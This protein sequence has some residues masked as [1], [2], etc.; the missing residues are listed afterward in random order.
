MRFWLRWSWRD[1]RA[2]WVQIA[3]IAL[4]IA[5]GTG[6][7]AGMISMIEWRDQ[8]QRA[9]FESLNMYDLRVRL[10]DG[11]YVGEGSLAAALATIAHPE[12]IDAAEERL[13]STVQV[14]VDIDGETVLAVGPIV[15]VDIA[16]GGPRVNGIYTAEGRGLSDAD[17]GQDIV[18]IARAFGIAHNLPRSGEI[19]IAGGRVLRYV[20]QGLSPEYFSAFASTEFGGFLTPATYAPLFMPLATA[21]EIT[22]QPGQVNDLVVALT[23][24][25][26]R[27]A[28]AAEI[29]SALERELPDTGF[30]I[31]RTEDDPAWQAIFD[32]IEND[33]RFLTIFA[34]LIFLGAVG[35]AFSL[36]SRVIESQRREIGIAMSLGVPRHRIAIRPLLAGAEIALLGVLFGVLVGFLLGIPLQSFLLDLQPL[37]RWEFGFQYGVFAQAAIIGFVLPFLATSIPVVRAVRVSPLQAMQ[38]GYR[39]ARGGGL[40]RFVTWLRIPGSIFAQIPVRNLLRAPRRSILT[41]LGIAAA[42]TVMV[43][44]VGIIDIFYNAMDRSDE[45]TIG[46]TPDRLVLSLDGFHP[47][48]SSEIAAISA[49]PSVGEVVPG[50]RLGAELARGTEEID[51]ALEFIDFGNDLWHPALR[52]GTLSPESPGILIA[53]KAADDL[54]V[55]VGDTLTVRH[56]QRVGEATFRIAASELP[57]LGI[58]TSPMRPLAY[59]DIR[60]A[61][62]TG[63]EG[64]TNLVNVVPAAGSTVDQVEE[65][66]FALEVVALAQP[67]SDISEAVRDF[68]ESFTEVLQIFEGLVLLLAL[69]I[70]FNAAGINLDERARDYATMFAYGIPVRTVL[71][72]TVIESALIGLAG[73]LL[74]I[75]GGLV[76]LRWLL[77]VTATTT[78]EDIGLDI[79]LEPRTIALV[80]VLGIIAVALAPL[81]TVRKLRRMNIS[82]TLR[83]M[84]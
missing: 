44:L 82:A 51:V 26:D 36:T 79:V 10:A 19:T 30:R 6:G 54:G 75:L 21:Q 38:T 65:E 66:M 32:D 17:A 5:L 3:V 23:S 11:S 27:E 9:A 22:G 74:G 60:H 29:K 62:L 78:L 52:A 49:S 63:L 83:V 72:M 41:V 64:V 70:A 67:V 20:G 37:P 61:D 55:D 77:A 39:A 68:I 7:Y 84:E 80:V 24:G 76:V 4:I 71:R 42:M 73:T 58:H 34:V 53:Q 1:L 33:R 15:G 35:A 48:A 16:D 69:L 13:L 2:R 18:V 46:V 14:R 12:S 81:L 43:S 47:I 25:A 56:P 45:A 57:V 50:L 31:M 59:V 8:S 40:A 28:I